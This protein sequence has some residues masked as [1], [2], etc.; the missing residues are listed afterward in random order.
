MRERGGHTEAAIDFCRLSG[1]TLAGVICE[2][3]QDGDEVLGKAERRDGGMMRRD[4]CLDFGKRWGLK[5]CTI[6]DLVQYLES[7]TSGQKVI[8][9]NR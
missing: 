7:H 4:G 2:L 8:N 1:K 6:E 5:V 9:G 3:V